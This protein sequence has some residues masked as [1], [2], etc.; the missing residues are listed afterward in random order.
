MRRAP[1]SIAFSTSSLTTEAGRSTTS[2]AAIWL[3]RS[4]GKR[5]ILPT[6]DPSLDPMFTAE[7]AEHEGDDGEHDAE[8]P[9]ELYR[10]STGKMRE[11]HVHP[12]Q[13]GEKRERHED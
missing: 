8:K 10:F 13:S 9:P 3:A 6:S 5:A 12:P 2:P 11:R 7:Q 1:A 4:A